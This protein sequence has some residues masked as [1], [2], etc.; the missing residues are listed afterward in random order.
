MNLKNISKIQGA[1]LVKMKRISVAFSDDLDD[2][3]FELRKK[4]EYVKCSYSEIIRRLVKIGLEV[5]SKKPKKSIVSE[6]A[7]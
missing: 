3:I 7:G 1:P 5:E 6:Q 2:G 4:D